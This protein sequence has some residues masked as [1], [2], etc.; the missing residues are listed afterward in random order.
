MANDDAPGGTPV[1]GPPHGCDCVA[2]L[3]VAMGALAVAALRLVEEV[4]S[5]RRER[6]LQAAGALR[7]K[8]VLTQ[9]VL[10]DSARCDDPIATLP[11]GSRTE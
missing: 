9:A 3:R 1:S 11:S 5:P 7:K 2:Y 10:D 8:I 4:E 6:L